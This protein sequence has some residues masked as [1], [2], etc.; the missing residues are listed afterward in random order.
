MVSYE[1]PATGPLPTAPTVIPWGTG[2]HPLTPSWSLVP[3]SEPSVSGHSIR[4]RS[5]APLWVL[6]EP[7]SRLLL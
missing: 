2:P 7:S 4:G 1:A 6:R 3:S 5:F